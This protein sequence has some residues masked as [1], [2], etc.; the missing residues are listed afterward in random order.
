MSCTDKDIAQGVI[1]YR[2]EFRF[3]TQFK[4][5]LAAALLA[6]AE[7]PDC[8]GVREL[9]QDEKDRLRKIAKEYDEKAG[10]QQGKAGKEP[11]PRP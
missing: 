11:E 6:K 5:A 7:Q 1:Q 10:G 8:Q 3:P 9:S 2:R 4:H